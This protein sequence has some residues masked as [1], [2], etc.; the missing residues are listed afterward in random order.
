MNKMGDTIQSSQVVFLGSRDMEK[1][2]VIFN[3]NVNTLDVWLDDPEKEF[4]SEE[5][6]NEIILKKD[7]AGRVIGFEKL[8]VLVNKDVPVP[9]EVLSVWNI[10]A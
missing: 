1:I 4:I 3:R 9:L 10:G 5:T 7:K 2:R 6:G 8:N